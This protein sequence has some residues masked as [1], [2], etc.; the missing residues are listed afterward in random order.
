[1]IIVMLHINENVSLRRTH[2]NSFCPAECVYECKKWLKVAEKW[3]KMPFLGFKFIFHTDRI[4][5]VKWHIYEKVS[6]RQTRW[7]SFCP[8]VCVYECKKWLKVFEKW[9]KM[10]FLVSNLYHTQGLYDNSHFTYQRKC[11]LRRTHWNSFL[12]RWV[13]IWVQKMAESGW[14][15]A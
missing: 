4:K 13:W 9:L 2:W 11:L 1:M 12:S 10:P 3:L 15:L 8:A 5:I 6:L 14:K 7:N